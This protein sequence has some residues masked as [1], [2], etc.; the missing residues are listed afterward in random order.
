MTDKSEL[1][2]CPFCGG[3]AA[4][5]GEDIDWAVFC[6]DSKCNPGPIAHGDDRDEVVAAWNRRPPPMEEGAGRGQSIRARTF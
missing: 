6:N 2:T 1:L 4:C 3:P 5:E